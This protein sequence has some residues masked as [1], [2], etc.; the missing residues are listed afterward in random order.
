VADPA[1]GHRCLRLGEV[2]VRVGLGETA[3][4][5]MMARN[6]F[7]PSFKIGVRAVAWLETD[8]DEWIALR[9]ARRVIVQ[10]PNQQEGRVT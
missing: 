9:A 2:I 10:W 4:R 6:E 5:Q 8:I 3:L 1:T 7:P